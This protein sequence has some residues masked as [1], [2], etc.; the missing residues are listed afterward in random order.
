MKSNAISTFRYMALLVIAILVI[1]VIAPIKAQAVSCSG[2]GCNG[3]DPDATGC[4]Q[5]AV[6]ISR[7]A[8]LDPKYGIAVAYQTWLDTYYSRTCGTNWVR[9]S[10]NPFGGIAYKFIKVDKKGGYTEIE[11]DTTYGASYSMMVYAPGHTPVTV[12]GKI[13][14]KK[15]RLKGYIDLYTIR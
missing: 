4:S 3:K 6:L 12:Y 15:N 9:V 11:K 7:K 5:S 10:Q 2:N 1:G 8:F 13:Y 14:D